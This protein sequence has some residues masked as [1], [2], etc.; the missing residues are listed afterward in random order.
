MILLFDFSDNQGAEGVIL[1][2]TTGQTVGDVLCSSEFKQLRKLPV[3][4]GGPV[5]EDKLSFVSFRWT[6]AGKLDCDIG[7]SA[8]EAIEAMKVSGTLVKAFA[9]KSAWTKGQLEGELEGHAWYVASPIKTLLTMPQDETLWKNTLQELSPFH[10]IISL[11]P[12]NPF[13]N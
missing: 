7:I 6:K 9:G 3:F 10:H 2:C 12:E 4:Y 11:T 5:D 13:L 1:N 8:P